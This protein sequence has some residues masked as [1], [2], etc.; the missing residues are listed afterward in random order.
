MLKVI[1]RSSSFKKAIFMID[2]VSNKPKFDNVFLKEAENAHSVLLTLKMYTLVYL[3][4]A[5][6]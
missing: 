4:L 5:N 6:K 2:N 3:Q 1:C